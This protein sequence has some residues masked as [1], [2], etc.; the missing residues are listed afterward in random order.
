[1]T[2]ELQNISEKAKSFLKRL[3]RLLL[4]ALSIYVIVMMGRFVYKGF[5]L[6]TK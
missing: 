3:K 2:E 6:M 4:I 1:M 5:M